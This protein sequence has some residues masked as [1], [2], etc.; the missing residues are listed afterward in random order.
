VTLITAS[1]NASPYT[2]IAEATWCRFKT[3]NGMTIMTNIQTIEVLSAADLDTVVGGLDPFL[4]AFRIYEVEHS[5][6]PNAIKAVQIHN[7]EAATT[8]WPFFHR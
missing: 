4:A 3:E 6:E 8:R 7:I 2:R 5:N 1:V